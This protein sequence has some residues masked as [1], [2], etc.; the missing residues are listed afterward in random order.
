MNWVYMLMCAD[1]SLY[2]GSTNNLQRRLGEH[3]AG[4]G[5][6]Y[7]SSHSPVRLVY[8]EQCETL[9]EARRKEARIKR[10]RRGR[11]MELFMS[12]AKELSQQNE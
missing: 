5:G 2:T 4:R 7:T 6:W 9:A 10:M 11:K 1:G 8:S 12:S 3:R